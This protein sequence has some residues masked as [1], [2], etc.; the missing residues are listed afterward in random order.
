MD[1]CSKTIFK[2]EKI[3]IIPFIEITSGFT[4]IYQ[5]RHDHYPP[6]PINEEEI[7]NEID[8]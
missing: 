5:S 7:L 3:K 6:P 2:K 1:T 8:K 4:E